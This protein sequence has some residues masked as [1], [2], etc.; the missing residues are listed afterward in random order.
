MEHYHAN[1]ISG[2][3]F[4]QGGGS[5]GFHADYTFCN[6]LF[7]VKTPHK[8]LKQIGQILYFSILKSLSMICS[9]INSSLAF[10]GEMVLGVLGTT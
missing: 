9:T 1:F 8:S 3:R 6:T 10:E 4:N 5:E 2:Q 7:W